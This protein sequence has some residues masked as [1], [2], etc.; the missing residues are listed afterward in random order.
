M[1][2]RSLIQFCS[3]AANFPLCTRLRPSDVRTLN[4]ASVFNNKTLAKSFG[5]VSGSNIDYTRYTTCFNEIYSVLVERRCTF[6]DW[7]SSFDKTPTCDRHIH[8]HRTPTNTDTAYIIVKYSSWQLQHMAQHR[9]S[10]CFYRAAL[11]YAVY[12]CCR[13]VSVRHKPVLYRKEWKN[14]TGGFLPPITH[15][16]NWD[17]SKDEAIPVWNLV[18]NSGL[19]KFRHGKSVA[20]SSKLDVVVDGRVCWRHLYDSRRVVA[21]YYKS[22]NCNPPL[23]RFAV[24]LLYKMLTGTA[25]RAVRLRVLLVHCRWY[26]MHDLDRPISYASWLL[27]GLPHAILCLL[28]AYAWL[29]LVF[30]GYRYKT[31]LFT[32]L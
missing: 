2:V 27:F 9:D 19:G 32:L 11:C 12:I 29:M 6:S 7:F 17:I 15:C 23:L 25:R 13:R 4:T 8:G 22:V 10:S 31:M 24:D 1:Q 5:E 18:S 28:L 20:L 14:R 16:A 30:V 3:S 21:V 26:E